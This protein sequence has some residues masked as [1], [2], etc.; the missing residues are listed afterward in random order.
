MGI[1]RIYV[2]SAC[3]DG[4]LPNDEKCGNAAGEQLDRPDAIDEAIA[5]GW[6]RRGRKFYCPE[7]RPKYEP[8]KSRK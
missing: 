1:R 6:L 4:I 3:C 2:Y 5:E 7:C 8:R